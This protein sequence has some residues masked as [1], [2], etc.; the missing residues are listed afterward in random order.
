MKNVE[1]MDLKKSIEVTTGQNLDWF[2]RQWVYGPGFPEYKV[3]WTHNHRTKKLMIHVR[4]T[5][6]LKTTNLFKMPISILIDN[7]RLKNILYGL[8]IKKLFLIF[9]A[10]IDQRWWFLTLV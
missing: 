10:A 9:P 7:G 5:Q 3:S 8:R 1:T 2:F 6:D 4:Q